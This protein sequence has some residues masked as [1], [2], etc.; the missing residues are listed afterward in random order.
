MSN[1]SR[2]QHEFQARVL[3]PDSP[4]AP[5]WVC[6]GGRA[7]PATQIAVYSYAYRARLQEVMAKDFPAINLAIGDEDFYELVDKY[8]LVHPSSYFSLR[9]FGQQFADF[10]AQ[11]AGY[12]EQPWLSELTTFEWMLCDAF[13]AAGAALVTEEE[14]AA[15]SPEQWPQL[16]FAVHP[17]LR[18]LTVNWNIPEIW[19]TLKSD[20]PHEV[21]VTPAPGAGWLIWRDDLITR[22]RSLSDDEQAALECLCQQGSFDDICRILLEFHAS[23]HVPLHAATYLKTWLSQGLLT[24]IIE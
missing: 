22:F 24:D 11:Q 14:I 2:L 18:C 16:R 9:D 5:A 23:E 6:A 15:I 13:D 12:D 21:Q 8:I 19:K 4:D 7:D 20:N 3:G 1:L 17:S 10:I